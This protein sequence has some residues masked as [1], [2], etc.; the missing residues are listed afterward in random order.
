MKRRDLL[1]AGA[2]ALVPS[3]A[4]AQA[5]P[6]KVGMLSPLPLAKSLLTPGI[7]RRLGELGY[8]EGRNMV[9][10]YRSAD[11][12]SERYPQL[13]RELIGLKCDIIFVAG[14]E[15]PA[16]ALRDARSTIPV[17]F[18]ANDYDPVERGIVRSLA[19][20][21]GNIT[22]VYVPILVLVA[23]RMQ[24]LREV[25]PGIRRLLVLSDGYTRDQLA[26]VRKTGD[27]MG[28]QIV[29]VEFEKAPYD[30]AAAFDSGRKADVQGLLSLSSPILAGHFAAMAAKALEHRLPSIGSQG[31]VERG[32]LIGYGPD[33]AKITA[34]V[35][36]VGVRILKGAKPADIPVE[37]ADDV[38]LAINSKAARTLGV[39]IPESVLARAT[40]VIE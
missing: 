18:L 32:G 38:E 1:A 26:V 24:I 3:A 19:R 13:A 27:A 16:R 29:V 11:G 4:F 25:S 5:R 10:E 8:R 2:F 23:K 22:G 40:R 28:M 6:V 21:D 33:A 30:L 15:L 17:V 9:L 34:K 12:A 7:V 35:A 37:Q 39:K 31:F 36:E 14:P 20:P